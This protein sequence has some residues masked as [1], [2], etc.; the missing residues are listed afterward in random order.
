[1]SSRQI[2][3]RCSKPGCG[4]RATVG[5]FCSPHY[6]KWREGI[7]KRAAGPTK[8]PKGRAGHKQ[9][10]ESLISAC[11]ELLKELADEELKPGAQAAVTSLRIAMD[12]WEE[13]LD[14]K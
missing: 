2:R 14:G 4:R 5:K 6:K 9:D 10:A 8:K 12:E 3:S 7:A 13:I 1:M 11:I